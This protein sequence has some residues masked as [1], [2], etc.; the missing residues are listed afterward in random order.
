ML[1]INNV[2]R[3]LSFVLEIK[4]RLWYI[5]ELF[6]FGGVILGLKIVFMLRMKSY[7]WLLFIVFF[8]LV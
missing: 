7:E 1:I 2:Y 8:L 6:L 4:D 3:E 5:K